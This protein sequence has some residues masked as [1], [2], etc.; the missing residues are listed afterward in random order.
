[1]PAR[2]L[3]QV[4]KPLRR[5]RVGALLIAEA[6]D[7]LAEHRGVIP[8]EAHVGVRRKASHRLQQR[9]MAFVVY[10]KT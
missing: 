2:W 4:G 5:R 7:L 9:A 1:M 10:K 3:T 8:G 6:A